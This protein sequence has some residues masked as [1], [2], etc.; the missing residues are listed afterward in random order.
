[1]ALCERQFNV[2][3]DGAGA[4]DGAGDGLVLVMMVAPGGAG[5]CIKASSLAVVGMP[6]RLGAEDCPFQHRS[7]TDSASCE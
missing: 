6:R 4:G 3:A 1:M 2:S 7:S 5:G